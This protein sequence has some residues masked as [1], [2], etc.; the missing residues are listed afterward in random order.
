MQHWGEPR[1]LRTK[2]ERGHGAGRG[3]RVRLHV[4]PAV[5]T[6]HWTRG[7]T[8]RSRTI[9]TS[10]K[11]TW[12]LTSILHASFFCGRR[13]ENPGVGRSHMRRAGCDTSKHARRSRLGVEVIPA[14][15]PSVIHTHTHTHTH[16][17]RHARRALISTNCCWTLIL[18]CLPR[19]SSPLLFKNLPFYLFT[20]HGDQTTIIK[21]NL[22][23]YKRN[24]Y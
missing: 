21:L 17:L 23:T 2:G 13:W 3:A 8:T 19:V 24:R 15:A 7:A 5:F 9:T 14:R 6:L 4:L 22:S 12:T 20:R 10:Q 1:G 11:T 18:L 16:T